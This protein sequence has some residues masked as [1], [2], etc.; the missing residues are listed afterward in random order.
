MNADM[1][2]VNATDSP[3]KKPQLPIIAVWADLLTNIKDKDERCA[4]Q[5]SAWV[6][7]AVTVIAVEDVYVVVDGIVAGTNRRNFIALDSIAAISR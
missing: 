5:G 2:E 3:P 7:E 6:I 4:I 1:V